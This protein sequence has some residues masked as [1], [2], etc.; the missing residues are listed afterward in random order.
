M[1]DKDIEITMQ[2]VTIQHLQDALVAVKRGVPIPIP[3]NST[4]VKPSNSNG[5]NGVNC[6]KVFEI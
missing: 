4:S 6:G 5:S 1:N 3:Q 2:K